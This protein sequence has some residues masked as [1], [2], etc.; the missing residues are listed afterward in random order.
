MKTYILKN[1]ATGHNLSL[2]FDNLKDAIKWA[3]QEET[4]SGMI[5]QIYRKDEN[6]KLSQV[7]YK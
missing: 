4:R 1:K 5:V 3:N 6:G 2:R 7:I